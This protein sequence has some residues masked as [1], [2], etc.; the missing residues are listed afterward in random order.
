MKLEDLKAELEL[1]T[2]TTSDEIDVRFYGQSA[3][4]I[5]RVL[6]H[7][8]CLVAMWEA[9]EAWQAV[10]QNGRPI[11]QLEASME[12]KK[13]LRGLL[14]NLEAIPDGGR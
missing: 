8:E 1:V 12:L 13:K 7:A 4:S 3:H 10:E 11:D 6:D 9:A 2:W 5:L 14:D